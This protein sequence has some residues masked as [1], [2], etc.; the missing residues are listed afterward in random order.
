MPVMLRLFVLVLLQ[1]LPAFAQRQ[2]EYLDRGFIAIRSDTNIFLS[3]RLLATDPED[4]AFNVYKD[5]AKLNGAPLR[6]ASSFQA[7][8]FENSTYTVRPLSKDGEG[9]PQKALAFANGYLSIPLKLPSG[10]TAND[11]S[12]GDLDG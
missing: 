10:Y 4:V 5:D 7:P 1:T 9:A 3:W 2:M 8:Y 11:A 6:N 12:V